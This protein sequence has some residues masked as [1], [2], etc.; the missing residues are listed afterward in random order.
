MELGLVEGRPVVVAAQQPRNRGRSIG[1]PGP[2][3]LDI[4]G[5]FVDGGARA[6]SGG[7]E[8]HG[9]RALRSREC[10]PHAAGGRLERG[11]ALT[12]R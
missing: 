6:R 10:H 3:R 7:G 11:I 9:G 4:N 5:R 1:G 8:P 2:P 12:A